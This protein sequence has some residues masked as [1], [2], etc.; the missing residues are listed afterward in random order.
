MKDAGRKGN[1]GRRGRPKKGSSERP[2]AS[3]SF[4]IPLIKLIWGIIMQYEATSDGDVA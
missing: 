2:S 4:L 1:L 3:P